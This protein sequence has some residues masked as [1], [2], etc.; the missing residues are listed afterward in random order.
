MTHG[1]LVIYSEGQSPKDGVWLHTYHTGQEIPNVVKLAPSV[2]SQKWLGYGII[3]TRRQ[4]NAQLRCNGSLHDWLTVPEYVGALVIAAQPAFLYPVTKEKIK[5][6]PSWS[7]KN[8]P[9]ELL[10]ADDAWILG[11]EGTVIEKFEPFKMFVDWYPN[12]AA[13][14]KE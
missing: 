9:Y 6:L 4:A 3:N 2:L 10:I 13:T 12:K 14:S 5:G 11:R 1:M 8:N 7:G